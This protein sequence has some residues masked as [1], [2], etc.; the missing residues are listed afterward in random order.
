MPIQAQCWER[1]IPVALK[2]MTRHFG[3]FTFAF[4]GG[5]RRRDGLLAVSR[6]LHVADSQSNQRLGIAH[7]FST[8]LKP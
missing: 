6:G 1:T 2:R 5:S 4:S 7:G 3:E 8:V